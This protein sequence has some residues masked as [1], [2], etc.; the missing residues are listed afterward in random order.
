MAANV[1]RYKVALN[2]WTGG[3][4]LTLWHCRF[5]T[6][7]IIS[8]VQGFADLIKSAYQVIA[9]YVVS[10]V[11]IKVQPDVEIFD[12]ATGTLVDAAAITPPAT[13]TG[14]ATGKNMSRATMIVARLNTDGIHRG[15][16]VHGRHFLGPIGSGALD[17]N[18]Q[19]DSLVPP[20]IV[21]AYAGVTDLVGGRL[22]V[23]SR[24]SSHGAG[25]GTSSF[26]QS[27][28][29]MPVPGVLRSRRD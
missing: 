21:T 18:G 22:V 6:V 5:A 7:P 12:D 24:P 29:V 28:G 27:V 25:D 8:D 13:I 14:A 15:H 19:I 11:T 20:K 10:G 1:Y 3:P 23:W 16:R 4:G 17:Q 26:V 2:G 9:E